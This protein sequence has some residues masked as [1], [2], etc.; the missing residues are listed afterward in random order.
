MNVPCRIVGIES[1]FSGSVVNNV[2]Q[3]SYIIVASPS[4]LCKF[5]FEIYIDLKNTADDKITKIKA[6]KV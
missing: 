6:K 2:K 3:S 1:I 4:S 5:S